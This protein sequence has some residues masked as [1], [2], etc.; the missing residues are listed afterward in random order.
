MKWSIQ[1][2]TPPIISN[3]SAFPELSR[4]GFTVGVE[5]S[6]DL[7]GLE[8]VSVYIKI[9]GQTSIYPCI[10]TDG[11]WNA[12]IPS[13]SVASFEIWIV[14]WDWGMNQAEST[15]LFWGATTDHSTTLTTTTQTSGSEI[16]IYITIISGCLIAI[17]A[18]IF[19]IMRKR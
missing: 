15:H 4:D 13:I 1:D 6:D 18:V 11:T 12:T 5:V 2:N 10:Y 3:W 7:S 16:Y 9:G 14:A 8:N 17:A 19:L